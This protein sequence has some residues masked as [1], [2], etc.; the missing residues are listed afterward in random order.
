MAASSWALWKGRKTRFRLS[1]F[2]P[3]QVIHLQQ[4]YK[5]CTHTCKVAYKADLRLMNACTMGCR[6]TNPPATT[7]AASTTASFE[8][9]LPPIGPLSL[10]ID[11][12]F[13]AFKYDL[14]Y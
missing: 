2:L 10:D 6:T 7:T 11:N 12:P 8:A 4:P 14:R 1:D 13:G 9:Q 5:N 3:F